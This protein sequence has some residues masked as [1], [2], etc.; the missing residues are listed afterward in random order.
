MTYA[1]DGAVRQEVFERVPAEQARL[2]AAG[3]H[4][5]SVANDTSPAQTAARVLE[6][7]GWLNTD[8][9]PGAMPS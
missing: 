1:E 6:L 8:H 3:V 9:L 7:A 2:Q 5:F 4:D